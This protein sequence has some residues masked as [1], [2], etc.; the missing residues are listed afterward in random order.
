MKRIV[1]ASRRTDLPAW[2]GRWFEERLRAGFV[3]Y[4][5]PFSPALHEVSLRREDVAAF[6]F[7]TRDV[8]PF[9]PVLAR[10]DDEG[11]PYYVHYTWNDYSRV[12]EPRGPSDRAID[13]L[14]ELSRR[15]GPARVL[16]RYDPIVLAEGLQPRDH[17][18]RFR[19]MAAR[20]AGKTER[21]TVSFLDRYRKAEGRIRA[22]GLRVREP[23]M[24][25]GKELIGGLAETA[26]AEGITLVTCCEERFRPDGVAAGSCVDAERVLRLAPDFA[27]GLKKRPTREGCR[28]AESR[29][30]GGYDTC[31]SGCVYCYAVSDPERA[32]RF[33]RDHRRDED[34]LY[35]MDRGRM[36][37]GG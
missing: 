29:D 5:T 20:L 31:P 25:E 27:E 22:T 13:G 3:R 37:P 2:Y 19:A 4:R 23:S 12:L 17:R 1:S 21:V 34:V 28:C 9:L 24:E 6:V 7:W 36:V 14:L 32:M 15:V 35:A 11:F 16:W 10:L 33:R 30:I 8:L 18:Q 26:A